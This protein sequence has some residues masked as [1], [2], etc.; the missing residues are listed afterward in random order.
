ESAEVRKSI[1]QAVEKIERQTLRQKEK[2]A[3][4]RR[5]ARRA[6][7]TIPP[8]EPMAPEPRIV[9]TPRYAIKLMSPEDAA[10]VLQGGD[11]QFVVFRNADNERIAVLYKQTNGSYGL[12][13]P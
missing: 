5:E 8:P 3:G 4:R 1:Q 10:L 2:F 9:R 11:R 13:E 12:I 6:S 7:R